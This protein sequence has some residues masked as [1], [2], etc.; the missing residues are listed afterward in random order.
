M[1]VVVVVV[2]SGRV[3]GGG[4]GGTRT[5]AAKNRERMRGATRPTV[6]AE[7]GARRID[8]FI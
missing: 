6:R 7:E 1:V 4:L 2:V 8:C 3:D 5:G